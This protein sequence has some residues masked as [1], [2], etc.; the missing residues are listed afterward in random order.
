[1]EDVAGTD[2][3]QSV[4]DLVASAP[5]DTTPTEAVAPEPA[6]E[7]SEPISPDA[8]GPEDLLSELN[9]GA[10]TAAEEQEADEA[11]EPE[12]EPADE[13]TP[14]EE[15]PDGVHA[16]D[17]N[18]KKEYRLNEPRYK[19]FHGAHVTLREFSEIAGEPITKEAFEVRNNALLA[20]H[21]LYGD[22]LSGDPTSQAKVIDFF[23]DQAKSAMEGG[24]VAG[25]PMVPFTQTFYSRLREHDPDAY[26]ALRQDAAKDLVEEMYGEAASKQDKSLFMS[27]GWIAKTLG[28][29]YKKEAEMQEFFAKQGQVDPISAKDKRI[30]E[31]EAQVNGSQ[32]QTAE[33]QFNAWH[34][35]TG[36]EVT[37]AILD[38]AI[39]PALSSVA[40]QGYWKTHPDAFKDLVVN[41][42]NSAAQTAIKG[43]KRFGERIELL[44]QAAKRAV[45]E[46]KRGEI[47]AQIKQL[48]VNRAN[49]AIEANK[50][51][52]IKDA[53]DRVKEQSA[54]THDRRKGAQ[55]HRAPAGGGTPVKRSLVPMQADFE[56]A[57]AGNLMGSLNQLLG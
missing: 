9:D 19:A 3:I 48:Y 55:N 32:R 38:E 50:A 29:P 43:D 41:R 56:V 10:E 49:L 34:S 40:D 17:R 5:T 52:V 15:L 4:G 51:Q 25:N 7:L 16:V 35:A 30:Q 2:V 13:A 42:L 12:A 57:T 46:Q 22:M 53:N 11:A 24:E 33:Q 20:E 26:G 1:M 54:A 31:L 6:D 21:R 8:E 14:T 47:R 44:T 23:F 37:A 39:T 36:R 45:S 28:L 27:T 18:G